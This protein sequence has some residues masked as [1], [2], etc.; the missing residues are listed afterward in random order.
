MI[1][2]NGID[3]IEIDRIEK[4]IK[5]HPNFLKKYFN[6]KEIEYFNRKKNIYESVAGYFAAK[7]AVSKSIGVGIREYNL[8]DIE[9]IK[10]DLNKPYVKLHNNAKTIVEKKGIKEIFLSISHCKIYAVANAV[11][12]V[13]IKG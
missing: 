7:E 10:D 5:R 11:A 1:Y 13:N 3:I 12:T 9:I 6:E 4:I 8:K 2:G